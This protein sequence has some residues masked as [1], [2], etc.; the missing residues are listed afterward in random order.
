MKK[1]ILLTIL[2]ASLL[3]LS[4]CEG[5]QVQTN[6]GKAFYGG[7]QGV[8]ANFELFGIEESGVY[9]I[10]DTEKFPIEVTLGNKGEYEVQPGD[11][12]V[13]LMG[14]SNEEFTGIPSWNIK[15]TEMVD[16]VSE[17]LSTG[18]EETITFGTD[19]SYQS[20]V[21][22]A[23]NR[24]WFANVDYKYETYVLIPEVCL[25]EDL[26]DNRVCDVEGAKEFFVSGAPITV[27]SVEESTAG[28]GIMALKVKISNVGGGKVT[29]L[30]EDFGVQ[31]KL[32]YSIDD[33]GWECKQGGKINEARLIDGQAEIICK[34][35]NALATDTVSTK[36]VKLTF[37]Y[38]YRDI[39][40]ETLMIKESA[41]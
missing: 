6:S 38:K 39:I 2:L 26:K 15:N 27:A 20:E 23:I 35:K 8:I 3:F 22:G 9:S 13:R 14:P 28:K 16:T 41:K 34:L 30:G 40:Q 4:A 25:K 17:L 1:L 33:A 11:V 21:T 19:V 12:E 29:K 31:E 37:E 32:T 18:G 24:E 5:E 36:Q 7:T 10:F